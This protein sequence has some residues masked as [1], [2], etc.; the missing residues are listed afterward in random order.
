MSDIVLPDFFQSLDYK[1]AYFTNRSEVFR[2]CF[3][4]FY[5]SFA[6]M[7]DDEY[8]EQSFS[9]KSKEIPSVNP[10]RTFLEK[11]F[12]LHE[13]FQKTAEKI[14]VDRLSRHLYDLYALS[15]T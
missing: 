10:E 14:R 11:I 12:L 4:E 13:E 6:E 15:K 2:A 3:F 5:F 7:V 9:E 1:S 8:P